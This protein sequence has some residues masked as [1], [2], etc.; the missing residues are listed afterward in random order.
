MAAFFPEAA[1]A[2]VK[3]IADPNGDWTSRLVSEY[4]LDLEAAHAL[5]GGGARLVT[6]EVP[7]DYAHWVDP[8][9]CDNRVGYY[10]VPNSR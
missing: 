6:V 2:Q 1:Y 9:A 3:A 4:R 7:S 5:V 10:E 8:G